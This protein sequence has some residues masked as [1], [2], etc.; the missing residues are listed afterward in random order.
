MACACWAVSRL[1]PASEE[2]AGAPAAEETEA[3]G[4]DAAEAAG[5]AE[6]LCSTNEA[7]PTVMQATAVTEQAAHGG[8]QMAAV[9]G[10]IHTDTFFL[11]GYA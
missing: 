10:T 6:R 11:E 5:T 7:P 2:A 1:L 8:P 9:M 3:A 4:A